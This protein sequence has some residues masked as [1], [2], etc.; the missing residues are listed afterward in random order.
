MDGDIHEG[1]ATGTRHCSFDCLAL[2]RQL[3][4]KNPRASARDDQQH[5]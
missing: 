2:T 1:N 3:D 5:A 4:P